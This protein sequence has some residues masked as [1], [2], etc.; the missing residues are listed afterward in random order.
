MH[1]TFTKFLSKKCR[2]SHTVDIIPEFFSLFIRICARFSFE[3]IF[4]L[5]RH[6]HQGQQRG[7]LFHVL[8]EDEV[9]VLAYVEIL[10]KIKFLREINFTKNSW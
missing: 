3:V 1:V 8:H 2:K 4:D 5:G 6:A 7:V 9:A 10:R